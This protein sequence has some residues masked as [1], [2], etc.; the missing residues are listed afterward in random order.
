MDVD[1]ATLH[2]T[3]FATLVSAVWIGATFIRDHRSQSADLSCAIMTRLL[4]SDKLIIE[5]TDIQKYIL[6][7]VKQTEEYFRS[8]DAL[9]DDLF[10]KAKA[11]AYMRL[12]LF[13]EIL[14]FSNKSFGCLDFLL[15]P[16]GLIEIED[17]KA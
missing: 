16:A 13:D 12:N 8:E 3:V 1:I 14:S 9:T 2:W 10:F 5:N 15:K 6:Q 17:W 4:E 7:S 11:F